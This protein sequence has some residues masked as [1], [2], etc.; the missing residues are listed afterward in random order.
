MK[1]NAAVCD[2]G[3]ACSTGDVCNAT[4]CLPGKYTCDCATKVDCDDKNVC[5]A[6]DCVKNATNQKFECVYKAADLGCDDGNACSTSDKCSASK[7]AAGA[8][9]AC[10]DQDPCTDDACSPASGCVYSAKPQSAL[11]CDGSVVNGRCYKAFKDSKGILW[12]KAEE[13]C[14]NWGGGAHLA[15][16]ATAT[17]NASVRAAIDVVCPAGNGYIGA[18]QVATNLPWA[19]SDN[20]PFAYTNWAVNQPNKSGT[21][22]WMY[23]D[24]TWDDVPTTK[25]D[26]LCYACER[27]APTACT[28]NSACTKNDSCASGKCAPGLVVNC[29]DGNACTL[30]SCDVSKGCVNTNVAD[31]AACGNDSCGSDGKTYTLKPLCSVGKCIASKT[32]PVNCNDGNACTDDACDAAKGCASVN[33]TVNCNDNDGCTDTDMCKV[34][35]CAGVAKVCT[36]NNVCTTDACTSGACK[37]TGTPDNPT[38]TGTVWRGHCY[39]AVKAN[40]TVEQGVTGCAGKNSAKLA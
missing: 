17:E 30:D 16:V 27:A 34:G 1:Q 22:A 29:D 15:S 10:D 25:S 38:C 23:A 36:D 21:V 32:A 11:V 35:K 12:N 8:A 18:Y 19:W 37:Y 39:E 4:K 6:D 5:T 26:G 20:T 28:D 33:N 9:I 31:N 3:N 40:A 14:S 13:A 7:C 2:D 24:G